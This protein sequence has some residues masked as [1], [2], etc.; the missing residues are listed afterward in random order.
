MVASAPASHA[1][2]IQS[3]EDMLEGHGRGVAF[4]DREKGDAN[5]LYLVIRGDEATKFFGTSRGIQMTDDFP[6]M[7]ITGS[8]REGDQLIFDLQE[9]PT[10]R[11]HTLTVQGDRLTECGMV[12]AHYMCSD[13]RRVR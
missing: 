3:A 13:Y 10:L 5:G 7:L 6:P 4:F 9:R 11:Q 1:Q 8:R 12:G 2:S